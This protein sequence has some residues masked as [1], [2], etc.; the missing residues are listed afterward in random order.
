MD[1]APIEWSLQTDINTVNVICDFKITQFIERNAMHQFSVFPDGI[2]N[3]NNPIIST[4]KRVHEV[5]LGDS[6][7]QFT[8]WVRKFKADGDA[9]SQSN[10]KCKLP[11]A[12]FSGEFSRR[13]IAGLVKYNGL[14]IAYIDHTEY[15]E[16][17]RDIIAGDPHCALAFVSP[18]GDG[19]KALFVTDCTQAE[20]HQ[21]AFA[22]V[23]LHIQ[24]TH[25]IDV[26]P[27]GSD[28]SRACFLGHDAGA[29]YKTEASPLHVD[30]SQAPPRLL[31]HYTAQ[32][33]TADSL[34]S[35]CPEHLISPGGIIQDVM[36]LIESQEVRTQPLLRLGAALTACGAI[37]G[38]RYRSQTNSRSNLFCLGIAGS[39]KGKDAARDAIKLIFSTAGDKDPTLADLAD[40]IQAED[41]A[42]SAGLISLLRNGTTRLLLWD[43]F[44][45]VLASVLGQR[46]DPHKT[47]ICKELL[48]IY[49]SAGSRM[50]GTAKADQTLCT[51]LP[52][53]QPHLTIW[54]T[55]TGSTIWEVIGPQSFEDGLLPRFLVFIG[56]DDP[57]RH[58]KT[59]HNA[60]PVYLR[61]KLHQA[62]KHQS[63]DTIA[64][65]SENEPIEIKRSA[66]GEAVFAEFGLWCDTKERSTRKQG[67]RMAP[68]W[69]RA[70]QKSDQVSIVLA[71]SNN[72]A[73]PIVGETEARYACDLVKWLT[74]T[75]I[76]NADQYMATT[77]FHKDKNIVL[78]SI[79][80]S[81]SDGLTNKEIARV[82][83]DKT[84]NYRNNI[85]NALITEGCIGTK[86]RK[87]GGRG[88][89]ANLAVAI[90]YLTEIETGTIEDESPEE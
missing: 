27:S 30:L 38:R 73:N 24:N 64:A 60:I 14:V 13:A 49:S 35:T 74:Q 85:V 72:P 75:F 62:Y 20:Y 89:P 28:I 21:S 50:A 71:W 65:Q 45:N 43:E 3:T 88:R 46:S 41:V 32:E 16:E 7:K 4:I 79:R 69:T 77:P 76:E 87:H 44:G 26:D 78:R 81:G 47:L 42:S 34:K 70:E 59:Y 22:S 54:G 51:L 58:T 82:M 90:E 36:S 53:D 61:D 39:G 33:R 84:N 23:A 67:D 18:S 66:E 57:P 10:A 8:E 55:T 48:R 63:Q 1:F 25:G 68:I 9:E 29:K 11:Y 40:R 31:G 52:I 12:C 5:L 80:N 15:A 83:G 37:M 86:Q 19:V 2:T 17:L 56:D 6:A